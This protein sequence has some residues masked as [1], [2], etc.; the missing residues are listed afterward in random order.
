MTLYCEAFRRRAACVSIARTVYALLPAAEPIPRE[1][2]VALADEIREP[3]ERTIRV[4]LRVA[5]GST[6]ADLR[7][8][9]RARR[10]VDRVLLV[11]ATDGRSSVAT[12]RDVQSQAILLDLRELAAEHPE[13]LRGPLERIAAHDA[14]KGTSY[15]RTLRIYFDAFG[16]VPV[17]AV[18][19][20]V[21]PNTFRYRLRR[22][23]TLFDLDLHDPDER[24][25]LGLQLRLLRPPGGNGAAGAA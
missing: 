4:P 8:L 17:A 18:G 24:L 9:P 5:V 10:E 11:L 3:A 1:R 6:V 14:R 2:V 21:H 22:L 16:D 25:V 20:G 23:A 7:D 12:I 15:L 13:I 19:A